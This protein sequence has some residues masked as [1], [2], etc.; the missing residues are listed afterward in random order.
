MI[1]ELSAGD[2][3]NQVSN[4]PIHF[5]DRRCSVKLPDNELCD[6]LQTSIRPGLDVLL[7][8]SQF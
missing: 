4:L 5:L 6:F 2:T 7:S 1:C 8:G 3:R